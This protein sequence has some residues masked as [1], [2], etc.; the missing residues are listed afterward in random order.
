MRH[1]FVDL[2]KR[3][4][5]ISFVIWSV[6]IL[7]DLLVA[8]FFNG[9]AII[10]SSIFGFLCASLFSVIIFNTTRWLLFWRRTSEN[11]RQFWIYTFL[12]IIFN[13]LLNLLFWLIASKMFVSEDM[14][15]KDFQLSEKIWIF[16]I[17]LTTNLVSMIDQQSLQM[18][19][20][21][22][23]LK[24]FYLIL[25]IYIWV[26]IAAA[27]FYSSPLLGYCFIEASLLLF[28]ILFNQQVKISVRPSIRYRI[29][30]ISVLL[31]LVT[32]SIFFQAERSTNLGPSKFLG[33]LGPQRLWSFDDLQR[34]SSAS[35]WI[36]WLSAG[37]DISSEQLA[38]AVD[39]LANFCPLN[40]SDYPAVIECQEIREEDFNHSIATQNSDE[41]LVKFL[42]SSV[43]HL[44]LL[45]MIES[46][47][48]EIFPPPIK[49]RL[50][51]ISHEAGRL[52]LVASVTLA[53]H[54]K[55]APHKI[56]ISVHATK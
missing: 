6:F 21:Q 16:T 51:R 54:G 52:G 22:K 13:N 29:A 23:P 48:F 33:A 41:D 15:F 24:N 40:P 38:Q 46:R 37:K 28:F 17:T 3:I 14:Y 4:G 50:E 35:E 53:H 25:K 7:F 45:A 10:F 12:L 30:G 49:E 34:V 18:R 55:G 43:D 1:M 42:D 11:I 2:C 9:G 5:Q 27:V 47:K 32:T 56:K 44:R 36:S 8:R 39:K 20:A 19:N 26:A 31:V